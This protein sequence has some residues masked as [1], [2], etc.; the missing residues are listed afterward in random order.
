[1]RQLWCI[2]KGR[3]LCVLWPSWL[4]NGDK[5]PWKIPTR[6]FVFVQSS[7]FHVDKSQTWK[8]CDILFSRGIFD[9]RLR[10]QHNLQILENPQKNYIG[11]FSLEKWKN[12]YN[13][14][15]L[16]WIWN[17]PN[18]LFSDSRQSQVAVSRDS[19]K[20]CNTWY[21]LTHPARGAKLVS[22][23]GTMFHGNIAE[24]IDSPRNTLAGSLYLY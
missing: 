13:F 16:V 24:N 20:R 2:F 6:I 23:H 8:T 5:F 21:P 3:F 7:T 10:S 18:M 12:R 4:E 1:M 19:L 11:K 22:R 9:I 17:L 14:R 15:I